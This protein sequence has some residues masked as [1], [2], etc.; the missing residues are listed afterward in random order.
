MSAVSRDS[1]ASFRELE[2][3]SGQSILARVIDL[4][5]ETTP[6]V[7]KEARLAIGNNEASRVARFAHNLKGS[8]SNFG[9]QRMRDACERLETMATVGD[10]NAAEE[11][12]NEAEREFELVRIALENELM[13]KAQ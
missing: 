4:F 9:A 10:L 5:F 2:I 11:L 6:P 1:L 7:F 12:L 13:E 3:E 8:C